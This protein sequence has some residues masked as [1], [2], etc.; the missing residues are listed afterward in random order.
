MR[1]LVVD[2]EEDVQYLFLQGFRKEIKE[3]KYAFSFAFNASSA[4]AF[5]DI[6]K[7]FDVFLVISDINMPGMS[8]IDMV[9]EVKNRRPDIQV[10]MVTAYS[11][12]DN[13]NASI[14]NGALDLMTK[15]L[16]FN[17]LRMR[18]DELNPLKPALS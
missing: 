14:R 8:G 15:P 13:Y 11:D 9:T 12:A 1:I 17:K 2:D 5:L 10:I 4:L 6:L 3:G 18:L 16:D 7:P